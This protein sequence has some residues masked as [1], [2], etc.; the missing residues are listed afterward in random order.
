M[1]EIY[2]FFQKLRIF[3]RKFI[4]NNPFFLST[5]KQDEKEKYFNVN[6]GGFINFY[7]LC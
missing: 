7:S 2:K 5:E 4:K 3:E 6:G 1:K